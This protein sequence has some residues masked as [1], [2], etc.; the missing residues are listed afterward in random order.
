MKVD[1]AIGLL[2]CGIWGEKILRDLRSL[3]VPVHVIDPHESAQERAM[4]LG[5]ATVCA[6]LEGLPEVSGIVIAS[7]AVTHAE[8]IEGVL[9]RAI[10]IL[11]EK[12]LTTDVRS[13]R[14][15][16]A[17]AGSRLYVGHIWCY[18]PGIEALR[19]VAR[20]GELGPVHGVRTTR[21]NWTSPRTDVDS[22]WNLAPHDVAIA[23]FLLDRLP[24]PRFAMVERD[25]GGR[26]VGMVGIM[27][28]A[29]PLDPWAVFEVSNRFREKR[30]E[31]RLHCRDGVAVLPDGESP[32]IEL[33]RSGEEGG[34]ELESRAVP[35]ESA[36]LRE[37][38]AFL[39]HLAGGPPPRSDG[40]EGLLVV[41]TVARLR[42]L[43]GVE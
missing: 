9:P 4:A 15:V 32:A 21:T 25:A 28:G 11:C 13:A 27:G 40:A 29:A 10:P 5:A 26:S 2:G 18:H 35:S 6:S 24:E 41:E 7:P 38:R 31:V 39:A 34:A 23:L 42:E 20:S 19:E 33:T 1:H 16:V 30:R 3:S 43:A 17:A 36:L 14:R 12:P 37:L 22:T 8:M